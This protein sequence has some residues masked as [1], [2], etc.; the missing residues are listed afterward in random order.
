[1]MAHVTAAVGR[2][3]VTATVEKKTG[4]VR[5]DATKVEFPI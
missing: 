5:I 2:G 1:V 4:T 3:E